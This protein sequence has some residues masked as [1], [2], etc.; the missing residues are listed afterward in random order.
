MPELIDQYF[1]IN[2]RDS[3][4]VAQ[5][6]DKYLPKRAPVWESYI[7]TTENGED[8]IEAE[9]IDFISCT[10]SIMLLLPILYT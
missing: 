6:L 4:F 1:L 7:I 8:E 10:M 9:D 3:K 2:T 5:F